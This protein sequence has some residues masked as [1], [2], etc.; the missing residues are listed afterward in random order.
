MPEISTERIKQAIAELCRHC[1]S[2][3]PPWGRCQYSLLPITE[4]GEA[5][6]IYRCSIYAGA[7][8]AGR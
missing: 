7:K 4:Q 6:C 3:I 5:Y 8:A 2:G 1:K